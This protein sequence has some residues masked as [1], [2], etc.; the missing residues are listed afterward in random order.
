MYENLRG[1][2]P[3]KFDD[4]LEREGY[5]VY[6]CYD[7]NRMYEVLAPGGAYIGQKATKA[8]ARTAAYQHWK[9]A[10]QPR[11]TFTDCGSEPGVTTGLIDTI[12][13]VSHVIR[14]RDL[15]PQEVQEALKDL[16]SNSDVAW[17]MDQA[18]AAAQP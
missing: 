11:Q 10:Q 6:Y 8:D 13:T 1:V 17:L 16:F 9:Q 7:T 5:R 15:D 12:M 18:K 3:V 2:E 14:S 4:E